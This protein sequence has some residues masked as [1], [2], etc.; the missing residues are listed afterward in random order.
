MVK[1]KEKKTLW[2]AIKFLLVSGIASI[3]QLVLVNLLYFTMSRDSYWPFFLSNL[4][5][6]I[7]G[8]IQNKRTT[9]KS[10][11]PWWCFAVYLVLMAGLI[12]FST[13][14]QKVVAGCIAQTQF[15][16]LAPTIAA[17]C[18]GFIQMIILFPVE[19]FVLLKERTMKQTVYASASND[20]SLREEENRIIAYEAACEGIVLLKNDGVLP[21]REKKVALFGAGASHTVKGGTGSGEVNERYTD[22]LLEGLKKAGFEICSDDYIRSYNE[23]Y[24]AALS[25]WQNKKRH[26]GDVINDVMNTFQYPFG[27]EL[28]D[29]DI[30]SAG[31]DTA[32]YVVSRQ[33]GEGLDKRIEN[34]EFDLDETEIKNIEK[35]TEGFKNSILVINSGSYMNLGDLDKKVGAVLYI[36]QLGMEGAHAF[37]DIISG[38]TCPSGRLTDTWV[39]SYKDIPFGDEYSYLG[40]SKKQFY[41][42]G[43]YVGYKYFDA[44]GVQPRYWFG[45]GLSY[46]T[47][48]VS[49]K[50]IS[51]SA[52]TATVTNT[53]K[54]SGKEVVMLFVR[55]DCL[56]LLGF[57]KTKELKS[58][59]SQDVTISFT[60]E[61]LAVF[62]EEKASYIIPEGDMTLYLGSE[63][64]GTI[65]N[66]K[67][68]TVSVL[69]NLTSPGIEEIKAPDGKNSAGTKATIKM[70]EV[71]TEEI[72]YKK[73]EI[74]SDKEVDEVLAKLTKRQMVDLCVGQ[75]I[76]GMVRSSG[77]Y[78]PGAVGRT[79]DKLFKKGLV[80]VNLSD[81]P[82]G[83]RLLM[84]SGLT[85][86]GKLRFS[87]DNYPISAI[88]LLPKWIRRLFSAGKRT[89]LVYQFATAF[90]V[91]TALA[92]TWNEEL[93]E[94]VGRAISREMDEYGITYWLAPAVNIH[95]NP[96]CGRNFEY[97]SEDPV[98]TGKIASAII[99]GIQSIDGNYATV[100]H[101]A[102]NNSEDNRNLSDSI[103]NEKALREIYLK[104]FEIC[105]KEGKVKSVMTSYN[106]I[107]GTYAPENYE[108]C[109]KVLRNEWGFDGVVMTD[110]FSTGKGLAKADVAIKAGNDMFMP[111]Q[112]IDRRKIMSGADDESIIRAASYIARQILESN[113][114]RKKDA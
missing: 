75:G 23:E 107:N 35:M 40:D 42:Q 90:P 13:W 62:C 74:Y 34:G 31:C 58:G 61:Y 32:I 96:L 22:S 29:D 17:A 33:A 12:L 47:F 73:A 98:L 39:Q 99:R 68:K 51:S 66:S 110:W 18:A 41:R 26:I 24:D 37:A 28:T 82:A 86:S 91:E 16:K 30:S 46:T 27:R 49:A 43:I 52:V 102:C 60:P 79:T 67:E 111:G 95:K 54:V 85:K 45:Y 48:S 113:I 1:V 8:Y 25:K 93:C 78:A 14:L 2:Q 109:T 19:K 108:L 114:N 59:E 94:E 4:L 53:G 87:G 69:E 71:E 97:M 5:A 101:F 57:A 81:G 38:K 15:D 7:Y 50:H 65:S 105:V 72:R 64:I 6:N 76:L 56:R 88:K 92:Q 11:A 21:L 112:G 36:C 70:P 77:N 55:N 44:F 84:Q 103:V 104:P 9:F 3:I 63:E 100:K 89:K 10:D 106:K 20:V 80:N 83:L